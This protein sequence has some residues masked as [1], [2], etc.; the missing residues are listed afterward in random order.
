MMVAI[1]VVVYNIIDI[2][3][4]VGILLPHML[5]KRGNSSLVL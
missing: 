1:V 5:F 4:Y 3:V 2:N